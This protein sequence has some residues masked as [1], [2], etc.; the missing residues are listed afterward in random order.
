M[1]EKK[2]APPRPEKKIGP[3]NA[4]IGVAVWLNTAETDNGP[5]KYRSVTIAPRRYIDR[6]T[7]EWKDSGSYYAG[8]LP[9]LIFALQKAQEY[10][11]ETPLPDQQPAS[12]TDDKP[13]G[14]I[15]F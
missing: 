9:A 8:D 5:K 6:D 7:G 12:P 4:G 3:F 10:M 15:P 13:S 14:D 11:F 2:A 1:S